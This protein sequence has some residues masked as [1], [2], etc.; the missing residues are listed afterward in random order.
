MTCSAACRGRGAVED[1]PK[2]VLDKEPIEGLTVR[3]ARDL[4]LVRNHTAKAAAAAVE[5]ARARI[6]EAR[7]AFLP[8]LSGRLQRE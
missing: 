7:A 5:A 2:L 8:T 4:A 3:R 6:A 1:P